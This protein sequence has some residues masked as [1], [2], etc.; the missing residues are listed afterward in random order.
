MNNV[1]I[2]RV[3]AVNMERTCDTTQRGDTYHTIKITAV[4]RDHKGNE[5]EVEIV[6]YS[7][8]EI[9]ITDKQS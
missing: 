7:D 6:L 9:V 8:K 3:Q 1:N 4:Q 5:F 2:H